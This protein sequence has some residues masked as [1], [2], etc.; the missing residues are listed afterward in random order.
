MVRGGTS[1]IMN[2]IL[3]VEGINDKHVIR[4]IC[5]ANKSLPQF[6]IKVKKDVYN[7]LRSISVEAKTSGLISLGIVLDSNDDLQAR[8]QSVR[9]MLR[10][11]ELSCPKKPTSNGTIIDTTP[12]VGIW[13]MPNNTSPGELEDFVYKMIPEDDPVWPMSEAYIEAIPE[14][15][16]QFPQGKMLR[17]K[18][19]AWLATRSSPR[20]MGTAIKAADLNIDIENCKNFM[21]WLR[22][23]F[24]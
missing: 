12:R 14:S 22:R 7:L 20:P 16:R 6:C 13:L 8:W 18:V 15:D 5:Q 1:P 11:A 2:R 24:G 19:H 17:A 23:L 9:D 3:L 4:N 10:N 21:D